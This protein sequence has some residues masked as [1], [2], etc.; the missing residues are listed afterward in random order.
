MKNVFN[1]LDG[2]SI[3]A[4]FRSQVGLSFLFFALFLLFV[5]V[6]V[7]GDTAQLSQDAKPAFMKK[8]TMIGRVLQSVSLFSGF[9]SIPDS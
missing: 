3:I 6:S 8:R 5:S 4:W 9:V 2:S 7:S 1:G